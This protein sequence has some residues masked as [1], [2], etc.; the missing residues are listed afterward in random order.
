VPHIVRRRRKEVERWL[1]AETPFPE[2][3]SE[4]ITYELSK[5]Y[6][7]LF[8][9]V[10]AYCRETVEAGG[11]LRVAQQRVRHWA[12]IALLRCLLSSPEA[13]VAVLGSR[14]ERIA[15]E[16][17]EATSEEVDRAYRPQVLD[18]LG[19][20]QAGDYTPTAPFEDPEAAW[21]DAER[22]RLARLQKRAEALAGPSADRKLAAVSDAVSGLL[23]DGHRPIVFCRFIHTAKYLEGWLSKQLGKEFAGLDVHAVTGE[24]GDEQRREKVA[25]LVAPSLTVDPHTPPDIP[26][27]FVL[28]PGGAV[29]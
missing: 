4:E 10:L 21:S 18:A 25:E 6:L 9:D 5:D 27:C 15:G 11:H 16:A 2:R 22:R 23:R 28:V 17:G 29:G 20:E 19:D 12:A 24:I 14:A 1:G 13:A 8:H 3:V 7:S 26:G